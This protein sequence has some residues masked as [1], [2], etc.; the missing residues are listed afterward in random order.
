MIRMLRS[1]CFNALYLGPEWVWSLSA[2][3]LYDWQKISVL[4]FPHEVRFLESD[5]HCCECSMVTG[6]IMGASSWV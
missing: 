2:F 5:R 4:T 3:V 1:C 6:Q